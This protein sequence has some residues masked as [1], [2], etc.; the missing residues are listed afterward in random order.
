MIS[1]H[2]AS[3]IY[4]SGQSS[5]RNLRWACTTWIVV[6][7][8]S[9]KSSSPRLGSRAIPLLAL[10]VTSLACG[11]PSRATA[12]I[13]PLLGNIR[14]AGPSESRPRFEYLRWQAW[15]YTM[16]SLY[17]RQSFLAAEDRRCIM[18]NGQRCGSGA[19]P[20]RVLPCSSSARQAANPRR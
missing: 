16:S 1:T 4:P 18:P 5:A 9:M 2:E 19:R 20:P 11:A 17:G 3:A 15:K 6:R 8:L 10:R 13:Q 12:F 14:A 7:S